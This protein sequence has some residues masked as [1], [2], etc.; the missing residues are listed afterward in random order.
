MHFAALAKVHTQVNRAKQVAH[1][2]F[3]SKCGGE[4]INLIESSRRGEH[5]RARILIC[6]ADD[7]RANRRRSGGSGFVYSDDDEPSISPDAARGR[8]REDWLRGEKRQWMSESSRR[9]APLGSTFLFLLPSTCTDVTQSDCLL[10]ISLERATGM[11]RDV[12]RTESPLSF[13]SNSRRGCCCW[14]AFIYIRSACFILLPLSAAAQLLCPPILHTNPFTCP[15]ANKVEKLV[16]V[17]NLGLHHPFCVNRLV[18]TC[19]C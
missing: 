11:D 8:G 2:H 17:N 18:L 1:S 5:F 13:F 6:A 3:Q 10:I 15:L 16:P 19:R 14:A 4:T 7:Q 9:A 12:G